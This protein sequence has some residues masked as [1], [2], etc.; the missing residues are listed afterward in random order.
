MELVTDHRQRQRKERE[1]RGECEDNLA[2][3]EIETPKI[4]ESR[5]QR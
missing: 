1:Q 3:E 4:D 2:K 5:Q